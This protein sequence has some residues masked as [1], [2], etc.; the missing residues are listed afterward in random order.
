M[1]DYNKRTWQ[2]CINC[3]LLK[4]CCLEFSTGPR[5]KIH[6]YVALTHLSLSLCAA[7]VYEKQKWIPQWNVSISDSWLL[8]FLYRESLRSWINPQM[9]STDVKL[10]LRY[11]CTIISKRFYQKTRILSILTSLFLIGKCHI[12]ASYNTISDGKL[13]ICHLFTFGFWT[14]AHHRTKCVIMS[15]FCN[16]S[17]ILWA[18]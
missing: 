7:A 13:L 11:D 9:T 6:G 10:S 15:G 8:S 1:A 2:Q 16:R 3:C 4:P 14:M 5:I 17:S 18:P 12:Q